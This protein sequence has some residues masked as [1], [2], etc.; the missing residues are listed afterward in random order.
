MGKWPR[1]V[2]FK[3]QHSVSSDVL[4]VTFG[5]SEDGA[6]VVGPGRRIESEW[7]TQRKDQVLCLLNFTYLSNLTLGQIKLP[8]KVHRGRRAGTLY[9]VGRSRSVPL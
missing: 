3:L 1:H 4:I 9:T 2:L 8:I 5:H 6:G 7:D